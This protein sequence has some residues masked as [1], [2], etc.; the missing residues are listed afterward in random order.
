MRVC[1][2]FGFTLNNL[3]GETKVF[4]LYADLFTQDM[5]VYYANG[6]QD[7]SQLAT[8]PDTATTALE[9]NVSRTCRRPGCKRS[10]VQEM[11]KCDF[12]GDGD[13]DA[14][15]GQ[16]LLDYVTG[17]RTS[18]S[19]ADAAD[20]NHDGQVDTYDVHLFFGK[21][22]KDTVTVP[23][24][25]SVQITVT[26]ELTKAEKANLDRY[27]TSGAYVQALSSMPMHWQ[28]WRVWR[29]PAIPSPCWHSM[30]TGPTAPCLMLVLTWNMPRVKKFACPIWAMST[31]TPWASP[32]GTSPVRCTILAATPWFPTNSIYAGAERR[33]Q[34]A[35]R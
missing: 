13:V 20:L 2:R 8:Y 35:G 26:M 16:A 22:G 12:D 34:R 29:A 28:P 3:T 17:A 31:Q 32:M 15:D 33:Q 11:A 10:L 21:L 23:A 24:N 25:G 9:A 1:I 18:I 5:F 14:D 27:Y 4:E 30:A 7:M 19:N 6:N